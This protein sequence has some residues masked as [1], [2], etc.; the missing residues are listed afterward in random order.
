MTYK[1]VTIRDIS[2]AVSMS[3]ASVSAVLSGK[4][5]VNIRVSQENAERIIQKARE[6]GYVPNQM[7]RSLKQGNS[8]LMAVFTYERMFPVDS[9]S[10]F[11]DFFVGIQQEAEHLGF[12]LLI[13]NSKRN[14]ASSSRITQASGAIMIG[15]N[16]DD[17]DI[18]SLAKRNFP[19]V[20]VG[21]REIKNAQLHVVTFDYQTIIRQMLDA[22]I[23][24]QISTIVFLRSENEANE[25]TQDKYHTLAKEAQDRHLQL[26][27]VQTEFENTDSSALCLIDRL[28][29]IPRYTGPLQRAAVLED[30][31]M[32]KYG[33]WNRW[34]NER[35]ALGILAVQHLERLIKHENM[36]GL[37]TLILQ[38]PIIINT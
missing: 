37:E 13:L 8:S 2:E 23:T 9:K 28:T 26:I 24:P 21:R 33:N 31:W 18:R 14:M 19:L 29:L 5:G 12:D 17:D 27:T 34:S 20:F 7:A 25:P 16:R 15:L 30:D 38:K 11:N 3:Y 35:R 1:R 22:L 36:D 6:M 4:N 32:G 10:E